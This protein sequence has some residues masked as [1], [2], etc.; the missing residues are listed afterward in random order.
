VRLA[1]L[2]EANFSG[3]VTLIGIVAD[4]TTRTYAVEVSV[5]NPDHRLRV[6]M[7]AEARVR[8]DRESRAIS[9][10]T[11]AVTRD[12]DGVSRLYV[13]DTTARRARARRVELGATRDNAIEVTQGLSAGELV[14]VAGQHRV[15]DGSRVIVASDAVMSGRRT[16]GAQ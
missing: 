7:V 13:V 4:P 9:V 3:R 2:P 14:V 11:N 12:A 6:G 1:A 10:P 8:M 15:R 5:P 16:G